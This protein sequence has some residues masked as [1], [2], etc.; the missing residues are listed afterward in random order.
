MPLIS[1]VVEIR[2]L[3]RKVTLIL[4]L[5]ENILLLIPVPWGVDLTEVLYDEVASFNP[6]LSLAEDTYTFRMDSEVSLDI[7]FHH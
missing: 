3:F 4:A 6:I 7:V 2:K 1:Y 5:L